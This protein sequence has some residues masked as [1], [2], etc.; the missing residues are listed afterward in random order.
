MT[1]AMR[2]RMHHCE[3]KCEIPNI[4]INLFEDCKRYLATNFNYRGCLDNFSEDD[5]FLARQWHIYPGRD[6]VI[7]DNCDTIYLRD[8]NGL[9]VDKYFY[10]W[11]FTNFF[12]L[13]VMKI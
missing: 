12:L 5:D 2:A 11:F 7:T 4:P 3:L 13:R 8:N 1:G 9:F 10:G 6:I